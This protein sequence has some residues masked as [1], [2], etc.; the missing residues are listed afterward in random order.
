MGLQYVWEKMQTDKKAIYLHS[1]QI[2]DYI[3]AFPQR[4]VVNIAHTYIYIYIYMLHTLLI[5]QISHPF[6]NSMFFFFPYWIR[7]GKFSFLYPYIEKSKTKRYLSWQKKYRF[8]RTFKYEIVCTVK[9]K[10][11]CTLK[12]V[13]DSMTSEMKVLC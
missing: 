8:I 13:W 2:N 1:S 6:R 12:N 7:S 10:S 4:L 5:W 3:T 11:T 9:L